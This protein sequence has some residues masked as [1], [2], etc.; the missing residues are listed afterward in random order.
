MKATYLKRI[1]L[2]VTA[3]IILLA[4]MACTSG[5]ESEPPAKEEKPAVTEKIS[6]QKEWEETL[7]AARKEGRLNI[8]ITAGPQV[9]D[10]LI[11]EFFEKFGI[12]ADIL[13][14]SGTEAVQKI[15]RERATNLYL[16]DIG[17]SGTTTFVTVFKPE[18]MLSQL[19]TALILPE[20]LEPRAWYQGKFPFVDKEEKYIFAS[21]ASPANSVVVNT[22]VVK[23]EELKSYNDLL[24]QK[25]KGRISMVDPTI[26]GTGLKWFGSMI[27]GI[28]N[29]DY[30]KKLA[31]QRPIFSRDRRLLAE[32][33]AR[34]KYPVSIGAGT[35]P[36]KPFIDAGVPL[37]LMS[38]TEGTYVSTSG[39][40]IVLLDKAP[41]P[42]AARVFLNWFLSKEG[43]T[44][45][46]NA[47]GAQ[48]ARADIATDSMDEAE[49]RRPAAKYFNPE[50]EDFLLNQ[51]KQMELA[52]EIFGPLI[53]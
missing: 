22:A 8:Y 1:L 38:M 26:A 17:I 31:E 41:H 10:V 25:W 39:G 53:R 9:R 35:E 43:A 21:L 16:W 47:Y 24:N 14:L 19:R 15:K 32:W 12:A 51:P 40:G 23:P 46:Q 37:K 13:T 52:K 36:T 5:I 7:K 6:W 27:E 18:G 11:K 45:Y 20:V 48:S 4:L 50:N 44:I 30:M 33:L 3:G 29:V 49:L 2:C 34:E 42:N 28:M